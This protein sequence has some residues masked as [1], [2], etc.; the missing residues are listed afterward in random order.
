[1]TSI[2]ERI[3]ELNSKLLSYEQLLSDLKSSE[4]Q[5]RSEIGTKE[6]ELEDWRAKLEVCQNER[7]EIK[8]EVKDKVK[9]LEQSNLSNTEKQEKINKLLTQHS[10]ELEEVDNL[11]NEERAQYREIR[12]SLINSLCQPCPSCRD[13]AQQVNNL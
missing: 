1:M 10:D 8:K 12:N 2:S 13:K 6:K 9:E 7:N 3:K 5:T 11:L 4:S